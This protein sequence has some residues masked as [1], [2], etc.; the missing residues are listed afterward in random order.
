MPFAAECVSKL[1]KAGKNVKVLTNNNRYTPIDISNRLKKNNILIGEKDVISS[2][3]H[4][5]DYLN[6]H[7][8]QK[9]IYVWGTTS[10]INYLTTKGIKIINQN[11]DVVVVLYKNNYS[12]QDLVKLCNL[13]SRVPFITGNKDFIYPDKT[14]IL[15]DTGAIT[16]L[17]STCVGKKPDII[18]GK[19]NKDMIKIKDK[20]IMIGDNPL[21]DKLFAQ[22]VGI[23][24][25]LVSANASKADISNLGVLCD[26]IKLST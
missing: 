4:V 11:P 8:A 5:L 20:T 6:Q 25:I 24:F 18:C 14:D 22:E 26:Y 17:I 10:A 9:N 21:T 19:P 12:Y 23:P 7:Y 15:P 1:K 3:K 2:L 13:C 16:N